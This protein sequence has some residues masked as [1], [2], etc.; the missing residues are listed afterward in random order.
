VV[1]LAESLAFVPV[2]DSEKTL[3]NVCDRA[4]AESMLA[5]LRQK[6]PPPLTGEG[7][8]ERGKRVVHEGAP[9]EQTRLLRELFALP[10]PLSPHLSS[11]LAFLQ[12]LV[13]PEI[14]LA[15]GLSLREIETEMRRSYPAASD[16]ENAPKAA[17]WFLPRL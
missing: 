7:L 3:R 12:H 8:L 6:A 9:L 14:S 16:A 5:I 17:A 1:D 2:H 11:G 4:T 10:V 13:L 15:L